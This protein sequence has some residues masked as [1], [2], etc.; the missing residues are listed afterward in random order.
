[1]QKQIA[2]ELVEKHKKSEIDVYSR[3]TSKI[4]NFYFSG[5]NL[6]NQVQQE[7]HRTGLQLVRAHK[8]V[9]RKLPFH[10]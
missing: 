1:M 10:S 9:N 8:R 6:A 7:A 2:K 3:A 4:D 5:T